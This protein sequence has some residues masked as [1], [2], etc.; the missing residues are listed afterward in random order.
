MGVH[1]NRVGAFPASEQVALFR[2]Q[3]RGTAVRGVDVQPQPLGS[4]QG[5]DLRDRIDAGRRCRSGGRDHAHRRDSAITVLR[6]CVGEGIRVEAVVL[7]CCHS[8]HGVESE[9]EDYRGLVD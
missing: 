9:P 1:D 2:Q 3:R 6:D 5:T 8:A 4:C 7:E